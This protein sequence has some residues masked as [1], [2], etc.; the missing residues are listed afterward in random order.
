MIRKKTS[1]KKSN[2]GYLFKEIDLIQAVITRMANNSFFIKGWTV[3]L[4]VATL[5][6]KGVKFQILISLLPLFS[7][8]FLDAYFLRQ[9]RMYRKLYNWVVANRAT[10]MDYLFD[11]NAIRFKDNVQSIVR[12]M[13]SITLGIFYGSILILIVLYFILFFGGLKWFERFFLVFIMKTTFGV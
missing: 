1:L 10:T 4:V 5:L 6:L 3:T 8:W 2:K 13:F 9:E 12:I 7:F 11:L